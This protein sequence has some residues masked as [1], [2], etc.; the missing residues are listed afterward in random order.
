MQLRICTLSI[1]IIISQLIPP[2]VNDRKTN[3]MFADRN[4]YID[5]LFFNRVISTCFKNARKQ[6]K[7]HT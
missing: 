7:K 6:N 3:L 4:C 2:S 1:L 5:K